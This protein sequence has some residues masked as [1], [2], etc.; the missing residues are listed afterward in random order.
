MFLM[1]LSPIKVTIFTLMLMLAFT[2]V[3]CAA[4]QN[5]D[6]AAVVNANLMKL[7]LVF[8]PNQGQADP[9]V[10]FQAKAEGHTIFFTRDNVVLATVKDDNP[11]SFSTTV[12][13]INPAVIV[14]GVDPQQGTANF[15]IGNDPK[16][17]QTG[18][19]TYGGV[20]YQNV[21]PGID[22]TYKGYNGLLKRE[23]TVAPGADPAAIV[24]TYNGIDNLVYGADGTLEVTT[25]SG[26]MTEA[27]PVAYQVI[28]GQ[29]TAV[30]A[31]YRILGD[32]KVGFNIGPYDKSYALVIDPQLK[33]S[34][35]LGGALNDRALGVAVD[36]L[37]YAYVTGYTCSTN[38][39]VKNAY[40]ASLGWSA[41]G[42]SDVF[43]TKIS[44][45]GKNL[46]Y[47]TY[48]GGSA[49][50]VGNGIVLFNTNNSAITGYTES[51]NFPF[52]GGGI[53]HTNNSADVFVARFDN[54][55]Q[56]QMSTT[57]GG[58]FTDVGTS[59]DTV[60]GT[61]FN[62]TGYTNSNITDGFPIN[63]GSQFNQGV[64]STAYDAFIATISNGGGLPT[65]LGYYGGSSND[66]GL[67]IATDG[68][69]NYITGWTQSN[70]LTITNVTTEGVSPAIGYHRG[71][72]D[73]F[74]AKFNSTL[75]LNRS[76]YLGGSGDDEGRGITV[77]N[78]TGNVYITGV[79]YSPDFPLE[80]PFQPFNGPNYYTNNFGDAFITIMNPDLSDFVWS[81]Y[82]GG[83]NS[84]AGQAIA[85][86]PLND[87]YVTGYTNSIDFPVKNWLVGF[88]TKH[89]FTDAFITM[90]ES[91]LSA[92][93]FSTYYGGGLDDVGTGIAAND[94]INVTVCGYTSSYDFPTFNSY[95]TSLGFDGSKYGGWDDGFV[96]KLANTP[97]PAF[98]V[99]NFSYDPHKGYAPLMVN[100]TD[101]STGAPTSWAWKYND[102]SL[103]DTIPNPTHTFGTPSNYTV[104]LTVSNSF[105]SSS[106]SKVV[107]V[108]TP[109][110]VK[111]TNMVTTD[112]IGQLDI[113]NNT[114]TN[115]RFFLNYT[116]NGLLG[117][118]FTIKSN[119]SATVELW[120][121]ARPD[122]MPA[123]DFLF[124][125][126]TLP[127]DN[128]TLAG[129]DLDNDIGPGAT[130]VLLANI[131]LMGIQQNCTYINVT[132]YTRLQDD[133]ATNMTLV[134]T[135]QPFYVL[136]VCVHNLNPI[137][138][139]VSPN[140]TPGMTPRDPNG[141]GLYEDINGDGKVDFYDVI[142]F[143]INLEWMAINDNEYAPFF[144]FN[145]NGFIDFGDVITLFQFTGP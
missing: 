43:L 110:G 44:P 118:N 9:S 70:N 125:N 19:P 122:W 91:N 79:T 5:T 22:L 61:S 135:T 35:Y 42:Y 129:I 84:D 63:D 120:A 126:S 60:D 82:L 31:Q 99:A 132:N 49:T 17:W 25:P 131:T 34:S 116:Q 115:I 87:I 54:T 98:P 16:E 51:M 21:L 128:L 92:Y 78:T 113:A 45:D 3:S 38:F 11:V 142:D 33:Y 103:N 111:F 13:G 62:V 20:D 136:H 138:M 145:H 80:D 64:A 97:T 94:T 71:A 77:S 27:A 137:P 39:P 52:I 88:G 141:D 53:Q 130:N 107:E 23:F 114:T 73:A 4:G 112:A 124:T 93:N 72:K 104:T 18:I 41:N 37:G 67:G 96:M 66:W 47:S 26:V 14:T 86:D 29:Q 40:D 133:S 6:G 100:F 68:S 127:D 75:A 140:W 102:G 134:P 24:I 2:G 12:A 101:L 30:A 83:Q 50:D 117:Y 95:K 57:F 15:Y 8:I 109:P 28:G 106:I 81:T 139:S 144:D 56:L 123:N 121:V 7:P 1:R 55:G 85:L 46:M 89:A 36:P 90:I 59:I 69:N 105:G 32:G 143:F 58:A 10:L 108:D 119:D 76:T 48:L 65:P 74:V